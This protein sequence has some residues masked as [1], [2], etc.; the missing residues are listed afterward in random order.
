MIR[1][2]PRSTLFPYTTLFRSEEAKVSEEELKT[3]VTM[4]IKEGILDREAAEIIHNVLDFEGTKVTEVMV[5]TANMEMI[6]GDSKLKDVI[7]YVVK[8]HFSRYPVYIDNPNKII[9]VLDVDDVLK[10]AKNMRLNIKVK[11]IIRPI[12][13]VPESKEIDDLL[14]EFEG[15]KI[16][17][18][19]VVNEYG[20][21][22][23]LVTVEDILE[24]IVGDIFDKSKKRQ[25]IHIKKVN[26]NLIRVDARATIEEI[27]KV[28]HLGIEA[29]PFETIAGFVEHKLQKIP[30]KNE[31]VELKNVT[32]VV[33]KATKQGIKS[34]K[35]I[36]T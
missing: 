15:K 1:R 27:N 12:S 21:V 4:G 23:G 24:E 26:K 17:L 33:D 10:Y 29:K 35:I 28:L 2:P 22:S 18:V 16:P 7:D 25:S 3:I 31:K 34:V 20:D 6:D 5:P 19:I 11:K 13:F 30:K 14:T 8:T 32:I 9:G 36:K